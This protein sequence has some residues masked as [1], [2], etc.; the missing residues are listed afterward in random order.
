MRNGRLQRWIVVALVIAGFVVLPGAPPASAQ[1]QGDVRITGH[2]YGHG[3]GLGQWG[4]LGYAV[5]HGWSSTQILDRFYGG[6]TAGS[7]GNPG[8]GVELLSL[9]GRDLIVT[10]PVLR[11]NGALVNAA[12]VLVRRN[13]NGTFTGQRGPGCGGPWT[14]F[15][16]SLASGLVV[17]NGASAAD[18]ANHV[19]VCEVTLARGYRGDFQ[20]VNTGTSS[21]VVNRLPL[22]DYLRGVLPREMPASWA[23]LGGGRGAQ[24][25]RSQAVAARSYAVSVPRNAYATTCDT[26]TC[27]VYGGEYTRPLTSLTRTSLEDPRT[28]AAVTATAGVVRRDSAGRVSRTEFSASTGGW[29]AGGAFPAVQDVGDDITS[30]P[31][32]NW[33]VLVDV[34]AIAAGLGTPP[35]T[36]IAVT[37]RNG[38]GADGGRVLQVVVDT[39]GGSFTVS[40]TDFRTA[41]GLRSDWFTVSTRSYT[42]SVSYA[43]ALYTDVLRRTGGAT[44]I[45]RWAE[46]VAA[47]ASLTMVARAFV[48]STERLRLAVADVYTGA[49][50][51]SPDTTGDQ[52]WVTYLRSGRTY[53]D[54][55]G[56]VYGSAESLA[57]L[58]GGDVRLWVDGLYRGL[59]G[60]GAGTSE[61][62][63][64]ADVAATR[65]RTFVA[66]AVS[67]SAEARQRRLNA[68]YTQFLQRPADSAGLATWM[69][70]LLTSGDVDVQ[71]ALASSVEYWN[72]AAARFP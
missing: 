71:I 64:W 20:V 10:A 63:R 23:D 45:T 18:P 6:T 16:P 39:T 19:Q 9:G 30:N 36:G 46:D 25:L 69:P 47:G 72:R 29:S 58:G 26:T 31:N 33:S 55:N 53:N 24:A 12:A 14:T 67:M 28:D 7:V 48:T 70:R 4:A 40:G 57:V 44:E 49:L 8:I 5:D 56:A 41:A 27:Q 66:S 42:Q 2:G 54:L 60:R 1:L 37:R 32:H 17:S 35:I 43:R 11:V 52:A 38:L 62:E 34:D 13:A 68:Y 65:G 3:R 59:L 21:A 50:R 61:R 51:R 22:E 15:H